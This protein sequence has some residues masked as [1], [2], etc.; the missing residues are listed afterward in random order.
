MTSPDVLSAHKSGKSVENIIQ[1]KH[2]TY[3]A[4]TFNIVNGGL[5]Y[6]HNIGNIAMQPIMVKRYSKDIAIALIKL[7]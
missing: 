3:I 7:E 2:P 5:V 6:N 1:D 4:D